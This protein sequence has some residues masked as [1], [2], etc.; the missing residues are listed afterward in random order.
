D[1]AAK[2][3]LA[4]IDALVI[5]V[6]PEGL[7]EHL[8]VILKEDLTSVLP[9]LPKTLVQRLLHCQ[10]SQAQE[11]GGVLLRTNV[12]ASELGTKELVR[13]ASHDVKLVR[14]TT[15]AFFEQSLERIR[16]E[17][18]SAIAVLDARWEDSRLWARKFFAEKVPPGDLT[19]TLLVAICD[20]VRPDVQAFGRELITKRFEEPHGTEYL[21]KLSEHPSA[22]LQLFASN[23]LER[24]ARGSLERIQALVPYFLSVLS[25]VNK[26]R[27][28][29][30]RALAFLL[31]EALASEEVAKIVAA[32]FTRQSVTIAIGDRA[33]LIEGLLAIK[34][35]FPSIEVP[36]ALTTAEVG[37]G[38]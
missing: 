36:L 29:K 33:H 28:A 3:A 25:R 38:V 8:L 34:K 16:R 19:P 26:G 23:F 35:K 17:L 21:L 14:E 30:E 13:L 1:F 5:K 6:Q 4:L 15:W 10:V 32:L 18:V 11:L 27:V 22:D 2:L 7:H 37:D 31:S 12:G 24:Y 20:S 9:K